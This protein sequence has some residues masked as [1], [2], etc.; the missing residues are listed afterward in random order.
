V[1]AQVRNMPGAAQRAKTIARIII[2]DACGSPAL[3]SS[4]HGNENVSLQPT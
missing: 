4:Q 1:T 2:D 3:S